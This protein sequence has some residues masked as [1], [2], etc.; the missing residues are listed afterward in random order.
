[1]TA[2]EIFVFDSVRCCPIRVHSIT[3]QLNCM[4]QRA[5]LHSLSVTVA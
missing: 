3:L 1:M 2:G 5:D 4:L